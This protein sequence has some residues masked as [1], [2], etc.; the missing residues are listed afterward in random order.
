MHFSLHFDWLGLGYW[1]V[2]LAALAMLVLLVSGVVIHKRIFR[3]F[4]TFRPQKQG[5]RSTL[6]LHNLTGVVALPFQLMFAL[7]G[8][9]IF[10][11]IYFPVSHTVLQPLAEK[12]ERIEARAKGLPHDPAGVAAPIASVDA[13][14]EE[15]KRR[16]AARDM[17]G[18]V[19]YLEVAHVH[20]TNGYVSIYRAGS[21]RVTL[22]GQPVYF[23]A[24]S[25]RVIYEAPPP[26]AVASISEFLTGLHLQHFRHWLL[27]WLYAFGGLTGCVCIATGLIF[28]VGKRKRKHESQGIHSAR[29]VDAL[30]TATVTG[31][32]LAT[33]GIL[34][35]NR[36]LP[37]E[38]SARDVWERGL[39]WATY[40]L[41]FVHAAVRSAPGERARFAPSWREQCY[42]I[43]GLAVVAVL[44]NWITTGDHLGR[45]IGRAYWPVAG[46]DLALLCTAAISFAAARRLHR[47]EQAGDAARSPIEANEAADVEASHA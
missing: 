9:V 7:T 10:A 25:G 5:Q 42:A 43:S 37:D 40:L 23:D 36:C 30:V 35:A 39:F 31:T 41:A 26:S 4:F 28:F 33:L 29:W 34:I 3:E 12:H 22:V 45:T 16:W 32:V 8:L 14:V 17:P 6:D 21:D 15:A 19:G 11:G 27:R 13:M 2:G 38:M 46:F 47:G 20:D 18:E 44:L 1:I 24:K